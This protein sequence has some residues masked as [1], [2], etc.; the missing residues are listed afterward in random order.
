M[1]VQAISIQK[2]KPWVVDQV[3]ELVVY[4]HLQAKES[5]APFDFPH[6]PS[7]QEYKEDNLWMKYKIEHQTVDTDQFS[8]YLETKHQLKP[9]QNVFIYFVAMFLWP[10]QT[11]G[12]TE[13]R[14]SSL[15]L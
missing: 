5:S 6:C 8:H 9:I 11:P 12:I 1:K 4:V 14:N 10:R 2:R 7:A 3:L 13:C 15:N